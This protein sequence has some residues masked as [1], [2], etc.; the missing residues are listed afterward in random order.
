MRKLIV[1]VMIAS[2]IAIVLPLGAAAAEL[3]SMDFNGLSPGDTISAM[4]DWVNIGNPERPGDSAVIVREP[5]KSNNVLQITTMPG[6]ETA[7]RYGLRLNDP[8]KNK[9]IRVRYRMRFAPGSETLYQYTGQ[10]GTLQVSEGGDPT[11]KDKFG[12]WTFYGNSFVSIGY[13]EWGD[14]DWQRV[15]RTQTPFNVFSDWLEFD[16][17]FDLASGTMQITVTASNG[18][19]FSIGQDRPI[20]ACDEKTYFNK[21]DYVYF[22]VAPDAEA[23]GPGIIWLDRISVTAIPSLKVTYGGASATSVDAD[24]PIV[25]NFSAPV[26]PDSLKNALTIKERIGSEYVTVPNELSITMSADKMTATVAAAGGLKGDAT[27]YRV[28]LDPMLTDENSGKL[29]NEA[30]G[31]IALTT[32]YS[33]GVYIN[34]GSGGGTGHVTV[35]HIS[36]GTGIDVKIRVTNPEAA[37]KSPFLVIAAYGVNNKMLALKTS[38]VPVAQNAVA[39]KTLTFDSIPA[40]AAVIRVFLYDGAGTMR[41]TQLPIEREL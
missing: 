26:N 7:P 12:E 34:S 29:E 28:E 24:E 17:V 27:H 1:T 25:L 19:T 20:Y 33:S 9:V 30:A 22:S 21:Y 35:T 14:K 23:I 32:K 38:A 5:G 6:G 39:D 41:L 40:D 2:L 15:N 36:G 3:V 8:A 31:R 4:G 16:E 18:D 10:F 11:T 37:D 13:R